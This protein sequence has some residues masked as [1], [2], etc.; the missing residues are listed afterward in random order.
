LLIFA[1]QEEHVKS[2]PEL[3]IAFFK[4]ND[5]KVVALVKLLLSMEKLT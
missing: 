2:V 4:S 5:F 3:L 1:L